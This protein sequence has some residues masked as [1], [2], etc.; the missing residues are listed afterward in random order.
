MSAGNGVADAVTPMRG[1]GGMYD[2]IENVV[3]RFVETDTAPQRVSSGNDRLKTH[4]H[5]PNQE[6]IE[7]MLDSV[8]LGLL[9]DDGTSDMLVPW[10]DADGQLI[11]NVMVHFWETGIPTI[12]PTEGTSRR[13]ENGS[14]AFRYILDRVGL[15]QTWENDSFKTREGRQRV[16]AAMIQI[17]NSLRLHA[18]QMIIAALSYQFIRPQAMYMSFN[19]VKGGNLA[20]RIVEARKSAFVAHR[21]PRGLYTTLADVKKLFLRQSGNVKPDRLIHICPLPPWCRW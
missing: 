2:S 14:R 18:T 7:A 10:E 1:A 20:L 16:V 13:L 4:V 3:T 8:V 5:V 12:V 11:W 15:T 19:E 6:N 17:V 21:D 9:I